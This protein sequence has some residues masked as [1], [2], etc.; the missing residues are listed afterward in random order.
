[1][2]PLSSVLTLTFSGVAHA[3]SHLLILL[4]ATIVLA[5]EGQWGQT[6]A[7]LQWL[8][9]P[10]FFLFGLAAPLWGWLGDRWSVPGMLAVFFF[11]TGLA[12]IA[13]GIADS[14]AQ[15]LCAL[16]TLGACA[17]IYHPIGVPW[18]VKN[19]ASP[20]R[21]LGINGVFGSLGTAL[22]AITAASL[23]TFF[24][25]RAVFV[26][27]GAV[28]I[29]V[30]I[31][32]VVALRA[33]LVVEA[34]TDVRPQAAPAAGT[35]ARAFA[36]MAIAVLCT[37]LVFQSTSVGLPKIFDERLALGGGGLLA[38]GGFVTLAYVVSGVAQIVGGELAERYPLKWVYLF[39]QASQI[40]VV[41]LAFPS[42]SPL[43]VALATL[44]VCLNV[45]SQPAENMLIARYTP[46]RWRGSVF[47]AK[48]MLTAGVSASGVALV[49]LI[50]EFAGT[51]DL[52][53]LCLVGFAAI[54]SLACS[55]LPGDPAPLP[56]PSAVSPQQV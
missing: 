50:H 12:A 29:A 26:V 13:T 19:A 39:A 7:D 34:E 11:G 28:S 20:S 2:T 47:G 16:T 6:Y 37:G 21:A 25:W 40:P 30:G 55:R 27:P 8:S 17:A 43:L 36:M 49:P 5:L 22:A 48:F 44:M 32:F 3:F 1:V 45:V 9:V 54:G 41:L 31:A 4:N 14:P 46:Q 35:R 51:L 15:L 42:H 18:L 23:A 53:F 52:L 56:R 38:V 10:G 24:G 33:R